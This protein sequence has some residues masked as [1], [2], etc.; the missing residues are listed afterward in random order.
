MEITEHEPERRQ[1]GHWVPG[2][3]DAVLE[4]RGIT[5]RRHQ[6]GFGKRGD[7]E[8]WQADVPAANMNAM[9][10][11]NKPGWGHG[12]DLTMEQAMDQ[13]IEVAR[14]TLAHKIPEA[15]RELTA[16]RFTQGLLDAA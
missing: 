16:L 10:Y 4:Y 12:G 8:D 7:R 3:Y 9:R 2:V 13:K 14:R 11:L 1:L 6:G 15:E 5:W